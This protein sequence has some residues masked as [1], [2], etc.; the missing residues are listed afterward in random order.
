[1]ENREEHETTIKE[2]GEVKKDSSF[3]GWLKR[4]WFLHVIVIIILG[5]I[6]SWGRWVTTS[7]Y[8]KDT[9]ETVTQEAVKVLVK[10][11]EELKKAVKDQSNKQQ[12]D[13]YKMYDILLDIKK[14]V[15]KK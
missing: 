1:M 9:K 6:F 10:E 15:K 2:L 4:W 8:A 7:I 11:V 12:E 5:G 13:Q 3:L 14:E